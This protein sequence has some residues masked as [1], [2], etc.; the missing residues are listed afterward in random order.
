M[1]SWREFQHDLAAAGGVAPDAVLAES[2]L[3]GDL[4]LDSL[5]LTEVVAL[6]A[7]E[8]GVDTLSDGL[9][10]RAWEALTA[11]D[12]YAAYSEQQT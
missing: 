5:A 11:G 3:V 9:D 10:E 2:T 12:L 7:V 1:R 6:L 4:G 8:Y